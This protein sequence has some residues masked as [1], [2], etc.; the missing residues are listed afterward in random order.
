MEKWVNKTVNSAFFLDHS[1][2][3]FAAF[4]YFPVYLLALCCFYVL[5][6]TSLINIMFKVPKYK[7][8]YNWRIW[9]KIYQT[10]CNLT[11]K[12][13]NYMLKSIKHSFKNISINN[14][15]F[16]HRKI[17]QDPQ[18]K[19]HQIGESLSVMSLPLSH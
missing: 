3:L 18:R 17:R 19:W 7:L 14:I 6:K 2:Y 5:K 16:L 10:R 11:G 4:L 8:A 9:N 15:L 13:T 12:N 1:R